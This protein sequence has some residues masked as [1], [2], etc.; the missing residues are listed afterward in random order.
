ML[1]RCIATSINTNKDTYPRRP[2]AGITLPHKRCRRRSEVVDDVDDPVVDV[3]DPIADVAD[4]ADVA[5]M[6]SWI[7]SA[8]RVAPRGYHGLAVMKT[9]RPSSRSVEQRKR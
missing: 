4:A 2:Y 7:T 3:A 6:N 8:P 1:R 5:A 9:S